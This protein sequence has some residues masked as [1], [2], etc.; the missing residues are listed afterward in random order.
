MDKTSDL[1]MENGE[2]ASVAQRWPNPGNMDRKSV[3]ETFTNAKH[4]SRG[5]REGKSYE[6]EQPESLT[7]RL[8]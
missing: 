4:I 8:R 3:S 6:I 5:F 2:N 1:E 7:G